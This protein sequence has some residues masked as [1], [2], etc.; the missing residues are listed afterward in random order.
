ME[1]VVDLNNRS[2]TATCKK[3]KKEMCM[4]YDKQTDRA[5]LAIGT[6]SRTTTIHFTREDAA[7][8]LGGIQV[9]AT[10]EQLGLIS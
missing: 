5:I 6:D 4:S 1:V 8:L 7:R 9:F 2:I 3:Q 10:A